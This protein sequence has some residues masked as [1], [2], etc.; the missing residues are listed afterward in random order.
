MKRKMRLIRCVHFCLI[1]QYQRYIEPTEKQ[2][3]AKKGKEKEK[4]K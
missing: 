1:I 2:L 4:K 3:R